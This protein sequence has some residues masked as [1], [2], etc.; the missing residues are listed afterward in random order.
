VLPAAAPDA[1]G[2]RLFGIPRLS[3]AIDVAGPQ[4]LRQLDGVFAFARWD[5]REERLIAGVDKLGMRP[6]YWSAISGGGY[7]VASEIKALVPVTDGPVVNWLAVEEQIAFGYQLGNHTLFAGIHRFGP[8]EVLLADADAMRR[9]SV[10]DFVAS[11]EAEP[12]SEGEFLEEND[13]AFRVALHDCLSAAAGRDGIVLTLSGGLDSRRL[14]AGLL[15]EGER[16]ELLTVASHRE[17]TPDLEAG[18]ARRVTRAVGLEGQLIRPR[19]S[20]DTD[21]IRHVRDLASDG[22]TNEH[23]FYTIVALAAARPGAVN[24]DGLAGDTL[25]NPGWFL[26]RDVLEP[27]GDERFLATL[28]PPTPWFRLPAMTPGAPP[29]PERMRAHWAAQYRGHRNRY[30]MFALHERGRRALALGPM[31]LQAH[32]FESLYPFLDRRFI[33]SALVL[34]P[35]Q[36]I[37]T[38]LQRPLIERLGIAALDG[39]PSTRDAGGVDPSMGLRHPRLEGQKARDPLRE[40]CRRPRLADGTGIPPREVAK[41]LAARALRMVAD[42]SDPRVSWN[43]M[44]AAAALRVMN[45]LERASSPARFAASLRDLRGRFGRRTDWVA[46]L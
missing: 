31:L 14:L 15:V 17:G 13:A 27:D 28:V 8:A 40:A 2:D 33:R 38:L 35:V 4:G 21:I 44:K 23:W 41:L 26:S 19:T 39:V 6:L 42:P 1:N 9:T 25:V 16:P 30:T 32:A 43:T 36:R 12:R 20:A 10:E 46:P 37:G 3:A 45:V 22:E 5:A 7:A 34:D 11:I 29:L 24:L 18:L